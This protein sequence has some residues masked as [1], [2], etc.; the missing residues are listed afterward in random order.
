MIVRAQECTMLRSTGDLEKQI[1]LATNESPR[2]V[3]VPR[4]I[5]YWFNVSFREDRGR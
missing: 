5:N 1:L 2:T 4:L 3:S